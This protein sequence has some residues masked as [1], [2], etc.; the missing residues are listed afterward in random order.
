[1]KFNS[2]SEEKLWRETFYKL[3]TQ[4]RESKQTLIAKFLVMAPVPVVELKLGNRRFIDIVVAK[5]V[6]VFFAE[7]KIIS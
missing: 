6:C 2:T 3:S 4:V 1:M 7:N 5:M